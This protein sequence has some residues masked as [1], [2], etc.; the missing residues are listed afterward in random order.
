[1]HTGQN[2]DFI[3]DQI[4]IV[5]V[6][7]ALGSHHG[8]L[9]Y[10]GILIVDLQ[11]LRDISQLLSKIYRQGEIYFPYPQSMLQVNAKYISIHAIPKTHI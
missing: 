9:L 11:F 5:Q 1:M 7:L 10:S 4:N 3:A 6:C 2:A 8:E